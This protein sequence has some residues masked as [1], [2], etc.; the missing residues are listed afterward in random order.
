MVV[1]NLADVFKITDGCLMV[2]QRSRSGFGEITVDLYNM[3]DRT[4]RSGLFLITE[5][6]ILGPDTITGVGEA[7]LLSGVASR[8][9]C[10]PFIRMHEDSSCL[11]R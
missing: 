7:R 9:D 2:E 1:P 6:P 8:D 11:Y 5:S 10:L 3:G 4:G